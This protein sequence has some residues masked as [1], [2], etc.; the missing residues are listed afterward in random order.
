MEFRS[1]QDSDYLHMSDGACEYNTSVR[2]LHATILGVPFLF[3]SSAM[4]AAHKTADGFAQCL[5]LKQLSSLS[6][7]FLQILA[8]QTTS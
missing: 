5:L 3:G 2:T 4:F 6:R 1:L 7:R 8:A